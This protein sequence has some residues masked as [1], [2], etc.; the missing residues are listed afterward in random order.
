MAMR[1]VC[2]FKIV[3]PEGN[4]LQQGQ[5]VHPGHLAPRRRAPRH[6]AKLLRGEVQGEAVP[7][8]DRAL[9]LWACFLDTATLPFDGPHPFW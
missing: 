7:P 6:T 8:G 4:G 5:V 3:R 2:I 1:A 9:T